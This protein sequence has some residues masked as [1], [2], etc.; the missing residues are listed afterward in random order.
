[1]PVNERQTKLLNKLFDAFDSKLTSNRWATVAKC[2]QDNALR[3]ITE[4]LAC[5][6]LMKFNASG[7]SSYKLV[8]HP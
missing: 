4:L 2:D 1:M 7:S 6:V 8:V 5:D 3:D